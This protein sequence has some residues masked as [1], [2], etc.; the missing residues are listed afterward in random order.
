MATAFTVSSVAACVAA[1][2]VPL[3]VAAP[4]AAVPV[5]AVF[6]FVPVAAPVASVPLA[7]LPFHLVVFDS[8]YF[9]S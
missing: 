9:P 5:A 3:P 6:V 1:P 4:V 7:D 2:F 8:S